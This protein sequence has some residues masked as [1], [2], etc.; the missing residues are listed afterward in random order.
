MQRSLII[1]LSLFLSRAIV[2]EPHS[3]SLTSE[4]DPSSNSCLYL[5]ADETIK[6]KVKAYLFTHSISSDGRE[7]DDEWSA[8]FSF[9]K[10]RI[11]IFPIA[12]FKVIKA[13]SFLM[14]VLKVEDQPLFDCQFN[15][16]GDPSSY[17]GEYV[18][19]ISKT[20][21]GYRCAKG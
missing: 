6:Q 4:C 9:T 18:L 14:G 5:K 8:K 2:A 3:V 20:A 13:K 11:A 15:F 17:A 1:I 7:D 10:P 19:T 12:Y 16:E 21:N